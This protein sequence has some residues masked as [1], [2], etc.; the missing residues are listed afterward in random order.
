MI[1]PLDPKSTIRRVNADDM[2][3]E[4]VE[5]AREQAL[6]EKLLVGIELFDLSCEFMRAGIRMQNPGAD[7][8]RVEEILEQRLTL[9]RRLEDGG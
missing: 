7:A 1:S 5:Q 9:A 6:G 3:W 8:D 2:Y 4:Q